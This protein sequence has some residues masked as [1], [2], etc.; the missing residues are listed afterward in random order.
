[1]GGIRAL[2]LNIGSASGL[3][4]TALLAPYAASKAYLSAW[5]AA[6]QSEYRSLG[7]DFDCPLPFFVVSNM[8]KRS[9]PTATVP[10]AANYVSQ[11]LAKC[12]YNDRPF[13]PFFAHGAM[14]FVVESVPLALLSWLVAKN[15]SMH[16]GIRKAAIRKQQ[17]LAAEKGKK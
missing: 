2:V 16:A 8:S 3:I 17:R 4:P 1:M 5:S 15:H 11:S 7:V 14:Q 9:R 12:G 6:L 10:T 13:A